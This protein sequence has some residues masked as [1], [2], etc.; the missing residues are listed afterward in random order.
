MIRSDDQ[1]LADIQEAAAELASLVDRGSEAFHADSIL[2]R[3]AERLLEIIGEAAT[4]LDPATCDRFPDIAWQDITRLRVPLAH[5]YHR[6]DPN[7]VWEI[8]TRDV[9]AMAESLAS[10]TGER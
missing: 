4:A 5:H 6:V 2:R 3:A 7:Q 10:G 1:R 9:P 8:A